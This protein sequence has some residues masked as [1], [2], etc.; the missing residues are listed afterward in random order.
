MALL[1]WP[2]PWNSMVPKASVGLS[3]V[4]LLMDHFSDWM[5]LRASRGSFFSFW[6][7]EALGGCPMCWPVRRPQQ[8][9]WQWTNINPKSHACINRTGKQ[10]TKRTQPLFNSTDPFPEAFMYG[11]NTVR[12]LPFFFLCLVYFGLSCIWKKS[13]FVLN[14]YK[15]KLKY[16]FSFLQVTSGQLIGFCMN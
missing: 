7:V 8:H 9:L 15:M 3:C 16:I 11:S 13:C 10:N 5:S 2:P 12:K 14:S 6:V 1:E 4:C